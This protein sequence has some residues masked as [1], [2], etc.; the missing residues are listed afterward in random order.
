MLAG[1]FIS[2][3]F[4]YYHQVLDPASPA[5]ASRTARAPSAEFRNE[6]FPGHYNPPYMAYDAPQQQQFAP[7][8]GP[9]PEFG[10]PPMYTNHD[11]DDAA[12]LKGD[13][14]FSDFDGPGHKKLGD[15]KENLV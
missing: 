8:P 4:A 5:N 2:I 12:T 1:L 10:K 3:A 7:P 6:Q 15:S 14:P 11:D 13:D 9:P